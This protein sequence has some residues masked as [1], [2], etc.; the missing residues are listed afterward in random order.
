MI[1]LQGIAPRM[2]LGLAIAASP[3]CSDKRPAGPTPPDSTPRPGA[4][5]NL[6]VVVTGPSQTLAHSYALTW[7]APVTGSAPIG[8][9]VEQSTSAAFTSVVIVARPTTT[10]ALFSTPMPISRSVFWRV[11]ATD[12]ATEED[13]S[14]VVSY[15]FDL[16]PSEGSLPAP[17]LLA[18]SDRSVF[19]IFPR[20]T[21]FEWTTV[22]GAVGYGLEIDY[23]QNSNP[24]CLDGV[25]SDFLWFETRH[26]GT[27][28]TIN[29]VGAQPGRWIVWA[30]DGQ[31][32]MG[33]KS[34]WRSF[35]Y[36]R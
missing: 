7:T 26:P 23:C 14:N 9:Q 18:P 17:E 2:I 27:T 3:G 13:A 15:T 22:A 21:T 8:Y 31:G 4:P 24:W 35:L 11:R 19:D 36:L 20:T 29:F 6:N 30:V 33:A 28:F 25:R 10:S 16:P 1:S 32:R 34:A 12:G 5:T